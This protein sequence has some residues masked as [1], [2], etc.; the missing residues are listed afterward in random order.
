MDDYT[1]TDLLILQSA[2][3]TARTPFCPEDQEIAGYFDGHL[4]ETERQTLEHHLADCRFCMARVGMLHRQQLE[5]G[6][7]RVPEEVLATAKQLRPGTRRR[8]LYRAP[9]WAAAAAIVIAV[10]SILSNS[11]L[12]SVPRYGINP[13]LVLPPHA[14]ENQLRGINGPANNLDILFPEPGAAIAPGSLIRWTRIPGD[15]HYTIFIL[16]QAGD[17]LWS[18]NLQSTEWILPDELK[19][20]E[21]DEIFFRVEAELPAGDSLSSKH[22][23]LRASDRR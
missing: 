2:E 14:A 4:A 21:G 9:A 15:T 23:V 7:H 12:V 22:R 17:V 18:E 11:N 16:S 20:P 3:L 5:T 10:V 13:E 6:S 19:L 1:H 8:R